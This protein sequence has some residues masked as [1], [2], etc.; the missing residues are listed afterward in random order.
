MATTKELSGGVGA[1]SPQELEVLR[2]VGCAMSVK[3]VAAVLPRRLETVKAQ[4]SSARAKLGVASSREAA[5][6]VLAWDLVHPRPTS[7]K[8]GAPER[9]ADSGADAPPSSSHGSTAPLEPSGAPAAARHLGGA[10]D[11]AAVASPPSPGAHD[12]LAALADHRFA[13]PV[14]APGSLLG[15]DPHPGLD[16]GRGG[17]AGDLGTGVVEPGGRHVLA[18]LHRAFI[19]FAIA[20]LSVLS[21]A[22]MAAGSILL[23]HVFEHLK[24]GVPVIS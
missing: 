4:L 24:R 23:M 5:R 7:P 22:G 16:I 8:G 11:G 9:G 20:A 17:A 19:V 15:R 12:R 18:L 14:P 1:L 13:G 6:L 21:V 10:G 3:E 2:L